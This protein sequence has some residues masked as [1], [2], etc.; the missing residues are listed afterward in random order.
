M[1]KLMTRKTRAIRLKLDCLKS[2]FTRLLGSLPL[3]HLG[4]ALTLAWESVIGPRHL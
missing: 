1:L 3:E 4:T 2:N